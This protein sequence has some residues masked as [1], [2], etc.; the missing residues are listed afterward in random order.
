MGQ[1]KTDTACGVYSLLV[2]QKR[3]AHNATFSPR[4]RKG[5]YQEIALLKGG[6]SNQKGAAEAKF[7]WKPTIHNTQTSPRLYG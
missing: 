3:I 7:L 2:H 1:G 5:N 6:N 4:H